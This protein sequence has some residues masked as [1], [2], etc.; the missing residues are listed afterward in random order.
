M[1][2]QANAPR[3]TGQS[4]LPCK[5]LEDF[6][7]PGWTLN[8]QPTGRQNQEDENLEQQDGETNFSIRLTQGKWWFG[9]V[10]LKKK[11]LSCDCF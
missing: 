11:I 2:W 7:L 8:C 4:S 1:G 6:N 10:G 9:L 3:K 5:Q